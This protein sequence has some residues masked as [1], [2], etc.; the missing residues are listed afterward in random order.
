MP[1]AAPDATCMAGSGRVPRLPLPS[2]GAKPARLSGAHRPSDG[3]APQQAE[4]AF[5]APVA[6]G[7]NSGPIP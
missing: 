7:L 3:K 6:A 2:L 4:A 5:P 1:A